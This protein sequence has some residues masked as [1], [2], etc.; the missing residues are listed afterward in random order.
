[1]KMALRALGALAF[2]SL[3]LSTAV[4]GNSPPVVSNVTASQ[5]PDKLVDIRY[6]LN[7]ADGDACTIAAYVSN[8]GGA[9]WTVSVTA[10]SGAVGAGVTP[11]TGKSITWD[12]KVDLPGVVGT[13][14]KVLICADD[15]YARPPQV[16]NA[17]ASGRLNQS[18]VGIVYFSCTTT[19]SGGSVQSV[20]VDLSQLGGSRTQ[21]LAAVSADRWQ[22]S[23]LL[24]PASSGMK[25]VTFSAVTTV[26][27]TGTAQA[28]VE[29]APTGMVV[30]PAGDYQMGDSFSVEGD[31]NERPR[32]AV[33]TGK[34]YMD[35]AEVTN[36][37]Y[38][39]GLNWARGQGNLISVNNGVVYQ[40]GSGTTYPYC[41]VLVGASS[42]TGVPSSQITWNGT[43]FGVVAG[44]ESYPAV[45]VSWYGAAAYANWRSAM[46]GRPLCYDYA[47]WNCNFSAGYRLPTE[48]EWERA[49][50][51][52]TEGRRFPWADV[53]TID[54]S[55]A[56]YYSSAYPFYDTVAT[57]G[58]H[59]S[60]STKGY[61][62]TCPVKQFAANGYGLYGMAGNVW[63]WCNDW[64]DAAYYEASPRENPRGPESGSNRVLRGGSW[65]SVALNLR[66][67]YRSNGVPTYRGM[68]NGFR[69]V[70]N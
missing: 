34:F 5:R 33:H 23:A 57:K 61:P 16:S 64:Y 46:H 3:F 14:F 40:S 69:V 54:F 15:G 65:G 63:E 6:D 67:A 4:Q 17:S 28:T 30:I 32:H 70:L 13:Q 19:V 47:T 25:Q 20:T 48:A 11:G 9:T 43:A 59:P 36:Q 66:C 37:Q 41:N 42:G 12:S 21:P 45:E 24:T 27:A 39:D 8:D 10:I 1:M 44:K 53:D 55:R 68:L 26:G 35:R 7:D 22:G 62:Y 52:G 56:N 50:R 60:F 29:V 18:E 49:A 31:V 51:G 58:Y 38:A 2:L